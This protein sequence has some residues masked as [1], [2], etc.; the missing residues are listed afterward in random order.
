MSPTEEP[1]FDD[2]PPEAALE[3]GDP[4][5]PI[6]DSNIVPI[7]GREAQYPRDQVGRDDD[8]EEEAV[9][10]A[11]ADT[12]ALTLE[13][14][15]EGIKAFNIKLERLVQV[16]E[17]LVPGSPNMTIG[18]T[19]QAVTGTATQTAQGQAG[20]QGT[21]WQLPAQQAQMPEWVCPI[22]GTFKIVPA[23]VSKKPPF[24]AYDAFMVCSEQGCDQRPPR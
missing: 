16:A 23:G 8:P 6:P 18:Q 10:Q 9:Q 4:I 22:H 1:K 21:P 20:G 12:I 13:S 17:R 11:T 3:I 15:D 2:L 7:G 14:I 24:R 19:P 5:E